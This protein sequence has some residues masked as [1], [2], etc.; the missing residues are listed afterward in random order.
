MYREAEVTPLE[1]LPDAIK[2][3][4]GDAVSSRAAW[5]TLA[6]YRSRAHVTGSVVRSGDPANGRSA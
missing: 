6:A 1:A 4:P 2:S 5:N 3:G